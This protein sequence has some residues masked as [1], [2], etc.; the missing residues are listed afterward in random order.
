MSEFQHLL[1]R[2][3][4]RARWQDPTP[5]GRADRERLRHRKRCARTYRKRE[6]MVA[7]EQAERRAFREYRRQQRAAGSVTPYDCGAAGRWAIPCYIVACESGYSWGAYNPSGAAGPY[8]I[9]PE[10]GRP[11]PAN[12]AAARL[13]HHRIAARIW[14]GGSGASNWACA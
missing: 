10:W 8:Q 13:E 4:D 9:M 11:W 14:A 3:F 12:S 1:D 5:V 7:L 2:A 6:K